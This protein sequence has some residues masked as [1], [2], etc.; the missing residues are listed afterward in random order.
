MKPRAETLDLGQ[1]RRSGVLLGWVDCL[2]DVLSQHSIMQATLALK[3]PLV[4]VLL[5]LLFDQLHDC[6]AAGLILLLT[7]LKQDI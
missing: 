5:Q 6:M 3:E 4:A 7:P 1:L 2:H